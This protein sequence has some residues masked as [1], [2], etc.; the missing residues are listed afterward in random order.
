MKNSARRMDSEI[1]GKNADIGR[2]LRGVGVEFLR[3]GW[4]VQGEGSVGR[5]ECGRE[6]GNLGI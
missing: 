3:E 5:L 1:R 4:R 2:L 6:R